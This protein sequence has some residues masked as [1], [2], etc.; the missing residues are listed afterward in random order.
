MPQQVE[1]T[2]EV[3]LTDLDESAGAARPSERAAF[4][5]MVDGERFEVGLG[6]RSESNFYVGFEPRVGL[7]IATHHRLPLGVT[8]AVRIEFPGGNCLTA[9]GYVHWVRDTADASAA[10]GFGM[11]FDRL[12]PRAMALVQRFMRKREPMF[13]PEC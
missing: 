9:E 2:E 7:F 4:A 1:N 5:Q 8:T 10:P 12:S 11:R 6:L 3:S 13:F